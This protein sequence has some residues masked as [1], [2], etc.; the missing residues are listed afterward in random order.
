MFG[1]LYDGKMSDVLPVL[2][3]CFGVNT[4][5]VSMLVGCSSVYTMLPVFGNKALWNSVC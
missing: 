4:V 1:C 5:Y 2:V 3:Q